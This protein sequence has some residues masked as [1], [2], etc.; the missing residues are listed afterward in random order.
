[1]CM[2]V[3][4]CLDWVAVLLASD[5]SIGKRNTAI[6]KGASIMTFVYVHL[7]AFP[8]TF[9]LHIALLYLV[10]VLKAEKESDNLARI[11]ISLVRWEE[12]H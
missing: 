10:H 3:R 8:I 6:A 7:A 12:P 9:N 2:C 1:M 4:V 5:A 11:I